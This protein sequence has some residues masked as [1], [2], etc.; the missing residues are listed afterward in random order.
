M[1]AIPIQLS[2]C[3]LRPG[4]SGL[5]CFRHPSHRLCRISDTG[6]QTHLTQ[7]IL[8]IYISKLRRFLQIGDRNLH[9]FFRTG[10]GI[11]HLTKAVLQLIIM[12]VLFQTIKAGEGGFEMLIGYSRIHRRTGTVTVHFGKLI[13]RI[14]VSLIGRQGIEPECLYIILRNTLTTVVKAAEGILGVLM[15]FLYRLT[16]P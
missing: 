9:I 11:E 12:A 3:I 1:S 14:G 5:C 10:S 6:F 13:I 15:I 2:E 8:G 7:Q 4:V 16:K